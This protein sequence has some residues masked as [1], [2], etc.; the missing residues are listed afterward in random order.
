MLHCI[1]LCDKRKTDLC[2][3]ELSSKQ[4]SN[5]TIYVIN[6]SKELKCCGRSSSFGTDTPFALVKVENISKFPII[7]W[8]RILRVV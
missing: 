3:G 1:R 7:L 6:H 8:D 4:L 5:P 2:N